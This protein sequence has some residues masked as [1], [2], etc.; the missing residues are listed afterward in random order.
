M[1]I[2]PIAH[3][4]AVNIYKSKRGQT[5]AQGYQSAMDQLSLSA[6]VVSFSATINKIK[7]QMELR[8][9]EELAHVTEIA[10]Q[11]KNGVYYVPATQVAE[12]IVH[13]YYM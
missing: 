9:P 8:A 11:V 6:D 13:D 12:K 1:K 4:A 7:E 3:Q 5:P 2:D 10:S